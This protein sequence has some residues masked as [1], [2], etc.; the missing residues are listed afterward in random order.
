MLE[1][2]G[3]HNQIFQQ[4][5]DLW[6]KAI[7]LTDIYG[8]YGVIDFYSK[9]KNFDIKPLIGVEL[10]YTTYLT[11]LTNTRGVA[12]QLWSVTLLAK[13]N[14]WYHNLLRIV[15]CWYEHIFDDIPCID[16]QILWNFSQWIIVL[17][18]GL[19]S[20]LYNTIVIKQDYEQAQ[21]HIQWLID[22]LWKDNVVFD[23]TA[24]SYWDYVDLKKVNDFL[25]EKINDYWCLAVTSTWY[26]YPSAFQKWAY[27]TALAIKDWKRNY[28]PDARKIIWEHHILSEMEIREILEKNNFTNSLIDQLID[29]TWKLVE[30]CNVKITL[31]QALFPNYDTPI[32][33]REAYEENKDTL[34][35]DNN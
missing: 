9:S 18:W 5:K 1:G 22:V 28:D 26:L 13:D 17:V 7:A 19:W 33:I 35:E 3:S 11:W 12:K 34:I 25:L 24:Q 10:P 6:Y 29:N 32:Q 21:S 31:W 14:I 16:S 27:E 2:I 30:E 20:S 8:L 15:S 23:I 4:A